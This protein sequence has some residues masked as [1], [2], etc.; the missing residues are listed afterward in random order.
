MSDKYVVKVNQNPEIR[1]S[2]STTIVKKVVVGTPIKSVEQVLYDA[3]TLGGDSAGF[4]R[5]YNNLTNKP[6]NIVLT[7]ITDNVDSGGT[8]VS[9]NIVPDTDVAYNLGSPDKKFKELF[10]AGETIFLGGTVLADG[11]NGTLSV[12][13]APAAGE[14]V[15][16]SLLKPLESF[17]SNRV[18]D[19]INDWIRGDDYTHDST[20]PN[21]GLQD[22]FDS[23][24]VLERAKGVSIFEFDQE[25]AAPGQTA[26]NYIVDE[27]QATDYRSLKYL[28]SLHETDNDKYYSSELLFTHDNTNVY[29][30][31]YGVL[32]TDSDLGIIDA[33]ISAGNFQLTIVPHY[34]NTQIRAKRINIEAY[35]V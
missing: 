35:N 30:T 13:P 16:S 33:N 1:V 24:Y 4:Y 12:G 8:I 27:F 19:T 28:I 10:L 3:S 5:D 20:N 15:D 14:A 25:L 11:G 17:D 22:F 26:D 6:T 9:G 2:E 21:P 18:I 7:G 34:V 32:Q 29:M 23:A 31:E